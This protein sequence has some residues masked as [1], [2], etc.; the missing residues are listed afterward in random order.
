MNI[1]I[2]GS[3]G[4][5]HALAWKIR[6]SR[7]CE[8]LF[9][10]P[11]NAGTQSLAKNVNIP[12]SDFPALGDFSIREKIGMV[13]AGPEAPLVAGIRDYF[14]S[15]E[16]LKKILFI[17]P[18]KEGA[19]LEG[20]K[21]FAK[22]F[23]LRH[24]IPTAASRTFTSENIREAEKHI[25]TLR[26]PIVLKADGLAAGKGVLICG[27]HEEATV[28][29][30][31]ML[32]ERMFGEASAKVIIE[33]YLEGIELS[34]FI[35]TDGRNYC[36]LPEAKDYKRIGDQD[37]GPNTG[38]MGAVSPVPFADPAFMEKV[39]ARIIRPTVEGLRKEK[40]DFR[41]FLF[42]GLMN[43][44]GDP[45]VIEYNVRMG[46]PE[47]QVVLPR[48][49]TDLVE[50]LEATALLKLDQASPEI[51]T[52]SAVAVVLASGGYPGHYEKG[53][54]LTGLNQAGQALIFHAGTRSV[55]G[56][57]VITNGGRV[58]AITG[59]GPDIE[60]ARK[61]AYEAIRSIS[62]EGMQF[63]KD[64]GMDLIRLT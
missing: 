16:D 54:L 49:K 59:Q 26:P 35:L 62:F 60:S 28:A 57:Q 21:D 34:V 3:G 50:L 7:R 36:L 32:E 52:E 41:G 5:E 61:K 64:I 48:L 58:L 9:V 45:Y 14:T 43:R 2:I 53:K 12:E 10:S 56:E 20:S 13:V 31:K 22:K 63:R 42:L 44:K 25:Q 40:I 23:M 55:D 39:E 46:D 51:S 37:T 47:S 11:G 18:G 6:Q 1:L 19:R 24:H 27:D 33:D 15:R 4:R 8:N 38:G 17:G 30:K 29:L